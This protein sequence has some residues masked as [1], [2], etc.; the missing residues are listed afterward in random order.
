MKTINVNGN[1]VRLT[2]GGM[3]RTVIEDGQINSQSRLDKLVDEFY[4]FVNNTV[5][6]QVNNIIVQPNT[7]RKRTFNYRDKDY[8]KREIGK[9]NRSAYD[10]AKDFDC[11]EATVRSYVDKHNIDKPLQNTERL[12]E[13]WEEYGSV[14][15][16][17][18]VTNSEI[19]E[20]K[21]ALE[22]KGVISPYD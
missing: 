15:K 3:V 21:I 4:P 22:Q 19:Y 20:V 18:N 11:Q 17:A 7:F 10:V 1:E 13:L 5:Q 9:K 6:T 14:A 8:L 2:E 16:I 12:E